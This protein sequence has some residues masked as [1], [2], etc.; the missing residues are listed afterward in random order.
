MTVITVQNVTQAYGA[1]VVFSELNV[2]LK[3]PSITVLMGRSGCGKSTLLRMFGGVRPPGVKTPTAGG[4]YIDSHL[5]EGPSD[6]AVTVFQRYSNRPDMTV[7]DNVALPFRLNLH[8][9]TPKAEWTAAVEQML[10]KVGL[11][12]KAKL[13]P[14]Q[15]SGG[16]NQR[17]ALARALVLKPKIL[18]LDEPFGALDPLLRTEMQVLLK[19]L[20][21]ESPC[22]VVMISHDPTEAIRVADRILVMGGG[23]FVLDRSL[24]HTDTLRDATQLE[25]DLSTEIVRS[26][27]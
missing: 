12:D 17:V 4:V 14:Y 7:Y 8:S 11:K 3:G 22:L 6:D 10:E 9:K 27:S 20:V 15:L 2:E 16:Q 13:M 19:R 5:C 26:L 23:K 21:T 18:L 1:N 24:P 25:A